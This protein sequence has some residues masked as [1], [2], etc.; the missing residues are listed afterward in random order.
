VQDGDVPSASRAYSTT[1]GDLFH[2]RAAF[3]QAG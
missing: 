3:T 2:T 1:L